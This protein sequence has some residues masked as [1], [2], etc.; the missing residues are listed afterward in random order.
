MCV[1]ISDVELSFPLCLQDENFLKCLLSE[2]DSFVALPGFVQLLRVPF[3]VNLSLYLD[4][5]YKTF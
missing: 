1:I 2:G 4:I 3:S 5:I